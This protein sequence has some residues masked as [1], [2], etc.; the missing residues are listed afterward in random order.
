MRRFRWMRGVAVCYLSMRKIGQILRA[1]KL[2]DCQ[3]ALALITLFGGCEDQEEVKWLIS[4]MIE[5]REREG[6]FLF[7][8]LHIYP[9]TWGWDLS[10]FVILCLSDCCICFWFV[11]SLWRWR[12]Q[13]VGRNKREHKRSSWPSPPHIVVLLMDGEYTGWMVGLLLWLVLV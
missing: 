11:L 2:F 10:Y 4:Q 1:E 9:F 7:L 5:W 12:S 8:G 3:L 6:W 13:V